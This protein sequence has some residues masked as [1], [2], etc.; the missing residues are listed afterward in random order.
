MSLNQKKTG[1]IEEVNK[2]VETCFISLIDACQLY[3][4]ISKGNVSD[5]EINKLYNSLCGG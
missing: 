2:L 4:L 3:N 1:I 5:N